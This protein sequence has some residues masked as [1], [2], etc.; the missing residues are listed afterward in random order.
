MLSL[1]LLRI[2]RNVNNICYNQIQQTNQRLYIHSQF[3]RTRSDSTDMV[4]VYVS[5]V[6]TILAYS[7]H[8]LHAGINGQ[9]EELI[10]QE[11]ALAMAFPSLSYLDAMKGAA[12]TSQC[13]RR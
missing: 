12:I 9:Q 4:T 5:N 8:L 13:V 3:K 11:R 10:E 2:K 7:C 6:S 1:T